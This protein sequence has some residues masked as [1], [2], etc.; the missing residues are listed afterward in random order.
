[1]TVTMLGLSGSGKSTYISGMYAQLVTGAYGCSIHTPDPDPGVAMLRELHA[2]RSGA[3][4]PPTTDRPARHEFILTVSGSAHHV[5][6]DL[7]DFRGAAVSDMAGCGE[8]DTALLHRRLALSDS[9]FV[10]IDSTH[11]RQPLTPGR[12]QDVREATGA[13]LIA[14]LVT[15]VQADRHQVGQPLPSIAVLLTKSDLIDGRT[16]STPRT[17]HDVHAE[18]REL[19]GLAFRPPAAVGIFPVSVFG[20]AQDDEMATVGVDLHGVADPM[21]FAV[22][23]FLKARQFGVDRQQEQTIAARQHAEHYLNELT[24]KPPITRW[25]ARQRITIAQEAISEAD[26]RITA[27][28]ARSQDLGQQSRTL[29]NKTRTEPAA[30]PDR[31]ASQPGGRPETAAHGHEGDSR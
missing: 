5:V 9:I 17:F 30:E 13:D 15:R 14:S 19:L 28:S 23:W 12:L 27:L 1:M 31:S 21:I 25:L 16:G 6:I 7:T 10:F 29:L 24:S 11:L 18:I 3:L 22:G 20:A 26:V 2:L 4:L 8:S